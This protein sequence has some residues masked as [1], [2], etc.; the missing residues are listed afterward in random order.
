MSEVCDHQCMIVGRLALYPYTISTHA[1][2][3][4]DLRGINSHVNLIVLHSNQALALSLLLVD[5]ID[6]TVGRVSNSLDIKLAQPVAGVVRVHQT[7]SR[8]NRDIVDR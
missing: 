3:V 7:I 1:V 2:R 8:L 6:K 4:Q 5:I